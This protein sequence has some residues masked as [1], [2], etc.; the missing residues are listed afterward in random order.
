MLREDDY[1]AIISDYAVRA[2]VDEAAKGLDLHPLVRD[3]A[4]LWLSQT[5]VRTAF[6]HMARL[7][8]ECVNDANAADP[9]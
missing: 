4:A 7:A 5:L 6:E 8:K 2:A 9:E 3:R 1:A